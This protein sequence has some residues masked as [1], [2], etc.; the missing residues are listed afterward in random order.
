MEKDNIKKIFY[1]RM[2]ER[3]PECYFQLASFFKDR[4]ITLVPV[5][6]TEFNEFNKKSPDKPHLISIESSF[7]EKVELRKNLDS[8]LALSIKAKKLHF[9]HVTSFSPVN[10]LLSLKYSH[11]YNYFHLPMQ[12][13]EIAQQISQIYFEQFD[14]ESKWPGG[15]RAKLP[16]GQ[17]LSA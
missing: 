17:K 12:I 7:F 5:E 4:G 14:N 1:L 15:H 16:N 8:G 3:L 9:Y 13:K 10:N 2:G 6:L 11:I